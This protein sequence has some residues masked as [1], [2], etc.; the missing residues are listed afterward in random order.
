MRESYNNL[1]KAHMHEPDHQN[2][3][4]KCW[5]S[6][7]TSAIKTTRELSS[8]LA[9]PVDESAYPLFIPQDF[10]QKIKDQGPNGPLWK[11]FV[12]SSD[13]A[14]NRGKADPIADHLHSK[15]G[16]V[17][18]RYK[19]RVLFSPTEVCPIQCRYCFRKNELHTNDPIFKPNISFLTDYLLENKDVEE[20]I[21]TGGDPL[22]LSD[23]RIDQLL[24]KIA[25]VKTIRMVRFHSRTPIILPERLT[26]SLLSVFQK[27]KYHFKAI[28]L[29]IHTNHTSE[30][31]EELF[32]RLRPFIAQGIHLLSQSVLLKGVNDR[33]ED[34]IQLFKELY[35]LG[36]NPYYLHHPDPVKG[37]MH[38]VLPLREGQEIYRKVKNAISG[39]MLPHYIVEL[40]NGRGKTIA[41]EQ[42]DINGQ[43]YDKDGLLLENK[44]VTQEIF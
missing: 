23:E 27:Y 15:S 17:I 40:P 36:V 43:W 28:T 7:F 14:N 37:A 25:K 33:P 35:F 19:N 18:H 1:M 12:P 39:V 24:A 9:E 30:L 4:E 31:S 6:S 10:A 42:R 11:Q 32:L 22:I 16:G 34:L 13:E 38:F 44:T 26:T 41:F 20:V 2:K 8:F 3:E 29:V 5:K 21:L